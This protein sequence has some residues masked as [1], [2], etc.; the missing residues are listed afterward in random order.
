MDLF[1]AHRPGEIYFRHQPAA[2]LNI[3]FSSKSFTL[4]S[5]GLLTSSTIFG[6]FFSSINNIDANQVDFFAFKRTLDVRFELVL[7]TSVFFSNHSISNIMFL[8]KKSYFAAARVNYF[9]S[10][11]APETNLLFLLA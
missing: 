5:V 10:R 1:P 4:G 9:S 2:R 8:L 6:L 3:F 11:G 7:R